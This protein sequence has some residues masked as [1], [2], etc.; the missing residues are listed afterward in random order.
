MTSPGEEN[1]AFEENIMSGAGGYGAPPR[2]RA[3]PRRLKRA[4]KKVG[5]ANEGQR[6]HGRTGDRVAVDEGGDGFPRFWRCCARV[7]MPRPSK[8]SLSSSPPS[9]V[10]E[11]LTFAAEKIGNHAAVKTLE[12]L[13]PLGAGAHRRPGDR[14]VGR[15]KGLKTDRRGG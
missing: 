3:R 14:D 10:L 7:I 11:G 13:V 9:D 15:S 2:K 1:P 6:H 12:K 5:Q 4:A 8:R